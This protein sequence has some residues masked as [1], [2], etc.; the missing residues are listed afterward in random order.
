MEIITEHPKF[1]TASIY[2]MRYLLKSD[3]YKKIIVASLQFLVV[4]NRINLFSFC[5]MSNHIHL[6]W[7]IRPHHKYHH[8]QRD[9]LKFTAQKIRFDLM[10]FHPEL[11]SEFEVNAKDRK[12]QF[13]QRNPLS[14]E[15]FTHPVFMQ[16]L[17]YIHW[18]PVKA[19][20]CQIPEDYRWSSAAFYENGDASFPFLTH[21]NG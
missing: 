3:A 18:N 8:V 16:K 20:I 5:I 13:W 12:Y 4:S 7:Q 9:F 19:G 10:E 14:I 17:E 1:F 15:L 21:F 6:I 11:L 2:K